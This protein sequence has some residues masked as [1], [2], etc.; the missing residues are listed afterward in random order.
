MS[1]ID[2]FEK[3][4]EKKNKHLYLVISKKKTKCER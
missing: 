3:Y 2:D 1:I 4:F